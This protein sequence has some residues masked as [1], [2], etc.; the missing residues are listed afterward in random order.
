MT[1]KRDVE[2]RVDDLEGDRDGDAGT[3]DEDSHTPIPGL[4]DDELG[5]V[6]RAALDPD[7]PD[8]EDADESDDYIAVLLRYERGEDGGNA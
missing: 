3:N 1:T 2:R 5:D 6:W 8:R 4:T 7:A